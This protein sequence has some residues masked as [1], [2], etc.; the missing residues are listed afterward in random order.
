MRL[1][2]I[3]IHKLITSA[4]PPNLGWSE[5]GEGFMLSPALEDKWQ[6]M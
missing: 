1:S 4:R 5:Q 2:K 6:I 3:A